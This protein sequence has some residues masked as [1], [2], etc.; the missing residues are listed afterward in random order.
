M[1]SFLNRLKNFAIL[2]A[3]QVLLFNH[4]HL[5]GYATAYIY[6]LFVLK[7]PRFATRNEQMLWAFALG[8]IVDMFGNTPGINA[9]AATMLAFMRNYILAM[10][11]PNGMTEDFVPGTKVLR[12]GAYIGYAAIGKPVTVDL[13]RSNGREHSLICHHSITVIRAVKFKGTDRNIGKM[14]L[15]HLVHFLYRREVIIDFIFLVALINHLDQNV[16]DA[17][18]AIK[19]GKI[20]FLKVIIIP[21]I[22]NCICHQLSVLAR[23]KFVSRNIYAFSFVWLFGFLKEYHTV[24]DISKVSVIIRKARVEIFVSLL[25]ELLRQSLKLSYRI[26]ISGPEKIVLRVERDYIVIMP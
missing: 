15:C 9:A 4:I 21:I 13:K 14:R 20:G 24:T 5:F 1:H 22:R 23:V 3:A 11:I 8:L 6:L 16:G 17:F 7:M 12:W 25:K 26:E 2:A 18:F 10:F 19:L